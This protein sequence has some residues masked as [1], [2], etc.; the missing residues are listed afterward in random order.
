MNDTQTRPY[1]QQHRQYQEPPPPPLEEKAVRRS[2]FRRILITLSILM[3]LVLGIALGVSIGDDSV[4][5]KRAGDTNDSLDRRLGLVEDKNIDLRVEMQGLEN[6]VSTLSSENSRLS[7]RVEDLKGE[8]SDAR[9]QKAAQEAAA[10]PSSGDI[11]V[12]YGDPEWRGLFTL[13]NLALGQSYGWPELTGSIT[14]NGGGDC[15]VGYV[16]V[17][18]LFYSGSELLTSDYTNY[19][20]L[21]EGIARGLT[22]TALDGKGMPTSAEVTVVDASC[23]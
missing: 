4:E 11:K 13:S 8:L 7:G 19:T 6:D 17:E 21:P 14:Y 23:E 16:E 12:N 2:A 1:F 3:S 10:P 9:A 5:L 22:I 18:A 15:P 20:S